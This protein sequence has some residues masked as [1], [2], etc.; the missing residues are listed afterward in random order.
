MSRHLVSPAP[1]GAEDLTS[2][3]NKLSDEIE[4]ER[5]A[6]EMLIKGMST[7]VSQQ[8]CLANCTLSSM[9]AFSFLCLVCVQLL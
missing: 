2:G 5:R 4:E 6:K 9:Y 3:N 8:L 1:C 7:H